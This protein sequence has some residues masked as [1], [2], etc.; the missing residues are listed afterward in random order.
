MHGIRPG[1]LRS[2]G[3]ASAIELAAARSSIPVELV[4]LPRARLDDTAES[5][6]Y[7]VTLESITNAH[8]YARASSIQIAAR[9]T[10][11]GLQL[12]ITD[13]GLG[14]AVEEH[15]RGLQGLRDR[16]EAIGGTFTL[17]SVPGVGTRVAAQIP[18]QG[19]RPR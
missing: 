6:A 19:V 7:Y 3:L 10:S 18:A 2:Y 16:V 1:V 15:G 17:D 14:G 11:K 4:E 12:E 13:D 5:T 9:T 8:R